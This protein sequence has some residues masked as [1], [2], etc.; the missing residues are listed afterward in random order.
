MLLHEF[1]H[2]HPHHGIVTVVHE[3][4]QRFAQL[5]FTHTGRAEKQ[6]GTIRALGIRQAGTRA[7]HS[8]RHRLDRLIL[9]HYPFAQGILHAQQF[10]PVALHHLGHG[11]AGP[12]RHDLG[13][14]LIGHLGAQQ[15][16]LRGL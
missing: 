13:D 16:V 5:G 15:Y 3:V 6:K 12:A 2:I 11:D 1:G 9:T 14:F 4:R 10:L 7:T 8:I